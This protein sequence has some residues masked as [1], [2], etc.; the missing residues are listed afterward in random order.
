MLNM[1]RHNSV[2]VLRL[3]KHEFIIS[4][5]KALIMMCYLL[6]AYRCYVLGPIWGTVSFLS[7]SNVL[8]LLCLVFRRMLAR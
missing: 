7:V 1:L 6:V 5:F 3:E 4:V 8:L 2:L